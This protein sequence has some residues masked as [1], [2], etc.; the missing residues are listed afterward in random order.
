MFKYSKRA[1]QDDESDEDKESN[2]LF[3]STKKRKKVNS[4]SQ[5]KKKIAPVKVA[6]ARKV[7]DVDSGSD[8]DSC[9]IVEKQVQAKSAVSQLLASIEAPINEDFSYDIIEDENFK[10]ANEL[11]SKIDKANRKFSS[12]DDD[13]V[14]IIIVPPVLSTLVLPT[15]RAR[16]AAEKL[17]AKTESSA[18]SLLG[19]L[20]ASYSSPSTKARSDPAVVD[21]P[22]FRIITRLNGKH[23]GRF[24]LSST[25]TF[26]K[27]R[28]GL[29]KLYDLK[30]TI[31]KLRFDGSL[32]D[33]RTTLEDLDI[34]DDF[35]IDVLIPQGMYDAAV[36]ASERAHDRR[37]A[38]EPSRVAVCPNPVA[39]IPGVRIVTRLNGKHEGRFK[40]SSTDTF[41]KLREG[42]GKLYD[43]KTTIIKLRFDGSL[44]DDRTTLEDLDIEDD[45]MIDVLIP[46]GMYDAAVSAS[47]RAHDRRAAAEPSR[48][49]VCPNPVAS[50]RRVS[51]PAVVNND[52]NEQMT[53]HIVVPAC[54]TVSKATSA[55]FDI[56]VFLRQTLQSLHDVLLKQPTLSLQNNVC[57]ALSTNLGEDLDMERTFKEQSVAPEARL[58]M[59]FKPML[60]LFLINGFMHP[61]TKEPITEPLTVKLRGDTLFGKVMQSMAKYVAEKVDK[62]S[63][64]FEG[65]HLD[66]MKTISLTMLGVTDASEIEIRRR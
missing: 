51:A 5:S 50:S 6:P 63:F 45:F 25:D 66:G 39:D 1:Y 43:L 41:S 35:M 31:I 10:K 58:I 14:N 57:Y 22:G 44:V 59:R 20:F 19:T 40:L 12:Q 18:E 15:V 56:K 3:E 32:V 34:E 4:T 29:G 54:L 62:L 61:Q 27:L 48:V 30:T 37:A 42:L 11:L 9:V 36:S 38:A 64:Y 46:Q 65:K 60:I 53:I 55:E 49:A 28:E 33:D 23:E 52:V 17:S 13:D 24:K 8:S 21:A 2:G 47:E 7:I 26:S 16:T